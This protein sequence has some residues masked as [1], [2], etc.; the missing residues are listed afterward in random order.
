M[1]QKVA[2]GRACFHLGGLIDMA[3]DFIDPWVPDW[4]DHL[5]RLQGRLPE[6]H[7]VHLL[8]DSVFVPGTHQRFGASA[9]W[10]AL[11]DG[12][13]GD[14]ATLR[15]FSPLTLTFAP[16]NTAL[17][18]VL[19]AGS[20]APA[21]SAV[22]TPEPLED[23]AA[24][25]RPWCVVQVGNQWFNCRFPDTRRLPGFFAALS[26]AQRAAFIGPAIA[27]HHIGRDGA[28][29][30]LPIEATP[31]AAIPDE[32]TLDQNQFG[33]MLDDAAVDEMLFRF[34]TQGRH[35]QLTHAARYRLAAQALEA[36]QQHKLPERAHL[37]WVDHWLSEAGR[38][39][40]ADTPPNT[41]DTE[42]ALR[43]WSEENLA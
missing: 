8:F 15:S 24:R 30:E 31:G 20:G 39:D 16:H 4:A 14:P 21:L 12:N 29:H 2:G 6:G 9:R 25:L 17:L 26:D 33:Q 36:A 27:W 1:P 41:P 43:A 42:T 40:A 19:Q 11:F 18:T 32:V 35:Q 37:D 7:H 10:L 38:A 23:W 34:M 5:Q 22:I 28:W 13:P 3:L